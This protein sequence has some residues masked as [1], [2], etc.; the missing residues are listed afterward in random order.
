M[1]RTLGCAFVALSFLVLPTNCFGD[2]IYSTLGPGD[3][4]AA[5]A[6]VLGSVS[7]GYINLSSEESADLLIQS[8][9]NYSVT[10]FTLA[11]STVDA[12]FFPPGY[13]RSSLF[14]VYLYSDTETS[15]RLIGGS[16]IISHVPN[17]ELAQIGTGLSAPDLPGFLTFSPLTSP[18]S[19]TSG[20]FYW[21]ILAPNN[22][23]TSVLSDNYAL[24]VDGTL[25]TPEP[26]TLT[27]LACA[28]PAL[29]F[30]RKKHPAKL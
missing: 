11:L 21:V 15:T 19:L 12:G 13:T 20:D 18:L 7:A 28:L 22:P 17:L 24:E 1:T 8:G 30:L 5:G 6:P 25:L 3:M 29:F 14:D 10:S 9:A 16:V 4:V 2:V 23:Q 26:A 27:L